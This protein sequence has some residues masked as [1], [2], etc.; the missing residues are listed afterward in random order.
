MMMY[1]RLYLNYKGVTFMEEN[2]VQS[3][4]NKVI[5]DFLH[6]GTASGYKEEN[7]TAS[8][9]KNTLLKKSISDI[10][11]N[12]IKTDINDKVYMTDIFNSGETCR[13]KSY[14]MELNDTDIQCKLNCEEVYVILEGTLIVNKDNK[15][16]EAKQGDIVSAHSGD[17]IIF[18]TP[19]YAKFLRIVYSNDSSK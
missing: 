15:K 18:S 9:T 3:L 8:N 5:C 19:F 14:L 10:D 11:S 7:N 4:V 2:N 12:K 16:I 17:C 13:L 6:T 1:G